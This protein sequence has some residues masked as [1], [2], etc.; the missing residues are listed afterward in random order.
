MLLIW[1]QNLSVGVK[2]FDNDHKYLI[3]MINE[4]DG[5]V[6]AAGEVGLID[7]EELE[8]TLHRLENYFHYHC[9][10][11][12]K[13]MEDI[14]YPELALHRIQHL[15]FFEKIREMTEIFRGSSDAKHATELMNYL[16]T[17]LSSHINLADKKYGEYLLE[18]KISPAI[19]CRRQPSISERLQ[20]KNA[21]K[22][23]NEMHGG[24]L[25]RAEL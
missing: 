18:K 5:I 17:W 24:E 23:T 19:Y 25:R 12:E 13:F 7:K 11:E 3:R 10:I 14:G 4:L 20:I 6:K 21:R 16:Y 15:S 8:L 1:T 9:L 22:L 2:N